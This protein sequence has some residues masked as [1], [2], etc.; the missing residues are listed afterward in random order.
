MIYKDCLDRPNAQAT[1]SVFG[2]KYG[3][4]GTGYLAL[5]TISNCPTKKWP[6]LSYDVSHIVTEMETNG[7]QCTVGKDGYGA[8]VIHCIHLDTQKLINAIATEQSQKFINAERGFIRFGDCPFGG[9]SK[10]YRDNTL[11]D[12][13]SVFEAEFTGNDYRLLSNDYLFATFYTVCDRPAYR[14]YGDVVGTGS[15]GEP[16]LKIKRVIKL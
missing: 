6:Y 2:D 15:D 14:A 9:R 11:E 1:I 13:V 8:P 16:V 5:S 3:Q 4:P 12:G 7:W 10:N